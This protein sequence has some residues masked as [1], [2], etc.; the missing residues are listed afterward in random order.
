MTTSDVLPPTRDI[1]FTEPVAPRHTVHVEENFTKPVV[2]LGMVNSD[3]DGVTIRFTNPVA[4]RHTICI[5]QQ[6]PRRTV[7]E[8]PHLLRPSGSR[9]EWVAHPDSKGQLSMHID[10]SQTP[11]KRKI[12]VP[13]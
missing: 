6:P 5:T 3:E 4:P 2:P 8:T 7:H 13:Q 10:R 1:G 9:S 11:I 12:H